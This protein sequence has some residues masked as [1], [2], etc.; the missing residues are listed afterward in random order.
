MEA[1]AAAAVVPKYTAT[2]LSFGPVR[3]HVRLLSDTVGLSVQYE[4]NRD[5][6]PNEVQLDLLVA[7]ACESA[8]VLASL[9][10]NDQMPMPSRGCISIGHHLCEGNFL[11][12]AAVDEAAEYM[13]EPEGA[14]IWLLPGAA[15]RYKRFL[16]RSFALVEGVTN[17]KLLQ[18]LRSWAV[19]AWPTRI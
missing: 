17:D 8:S 12:R 11:I 4:R 19:E 3:F 14:F 6:I 2:N 10:M 1:E 9:F 5:E 13:D 16:S 18:L 7:I 15:G